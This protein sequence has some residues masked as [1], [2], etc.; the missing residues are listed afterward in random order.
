MQMTLILFDESRADLRNLKV[1]IDC[2][3][4]VPGFSVNRE[5]RGIWVCDALIWNISKWKHYLG[6]KLQIFPLNIWVYLWM[7]IQDQNSFG[8]PS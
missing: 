6:A 4:L 8:I 2:F 3:D 1:L 7:E 5:K